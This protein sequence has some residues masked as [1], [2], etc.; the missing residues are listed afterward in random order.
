MILQSLIDYYDRLAAAKDDR[1]VPFG[2]SRQKIGFVIVLD[3]DGNLR[4]IE[5]PPSPSD[6][7]PVR[8]TLVV[9]GQGKPSG[10]GIN[11]CFLWDNATYLL[12]RRQ[13]EHPA[14]WAWERFEKLREEHIAREQE[15]SD[16]EYGAVCRFLRSWST[17]NLEEHEIEVGTADGFGV[18][19]IEGSH[20]Y[21]HERDRIASYWNETR[22]VPSREAHLGPS[23][24]SGKRV[25]LAR[26]HEPKIK[27]VRGA[28]SSGALL[29]S[30]NLDAFESYGKVQSLNSPLGTAEAFR[31]CN[32]LNILLADDRRRI[33]IG[34]TTTV[35]WTS[36]P[37]ELEDIT[38]CVLGTTEDE[39]L[40]SRIEDNLR[41]YRSGVR[42]ASV[43]EDSTRF[44]V[45]GLMPNA[46]RLAVRYWLCDSIASFSDR[47]ARHAGA[48][49]LAGA[50][51]GYRFPSLRRLVGETAP[52]SSNGWPDEDRVSPIL[53][54]EVARAVLGGLPYPR[55]LLIRLIERIRAEGFVDPDKRKDWRAAMH[56]RAALV[57]ACLQEAQA[58]LR[59][60]VSVS[61]NENHPDVSYQLG[62]LFAVLEKTQ[63]EAFG[64]KPNASVRDR[65]F[66]SAAANP[67]VAFPR[68]LK[69]HA[70][71]LGK[72]E[73]VGRRV[74]LERLVGS[75]CDAVDP[76]RGFPSHLTLEEQGLFFLGYYHQRQDL[77]SS[78]SSSET[79]A[80]QA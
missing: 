73:N 24:V 29:V 17:A 39:G 46:S 70:H 67:S 20:H 18:F 21:V 58:G 56:R 7:R 43:D 35:F 19:R 33:T 62:R 15:I 27:G 11:P 53:A 44:F 79:V 45:L 57:K 65:F 26:L 55:S 52:T 36:E 51:D 63:D 30:F 23:L 49:E 76:S 37:H 71:H 38:G 13:D 16:P 74:N 60:E 50:P 66:G 9:P 22:P 54:G 72:L 42:G 4:S 77:F 48:L 25:P 69:L 68:L 6:R 41:S 78:K 40:L 59:K 31:Y 3:V 1:T 28:Q 8:F 32:A 12:G 64:G 34:G 2:W 5:P 61:L 80:T 75:I 14:S 10:S 47:I